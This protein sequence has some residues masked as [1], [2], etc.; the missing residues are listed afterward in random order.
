[1]T[2]TLFTVSLLELFLGGGG[3]LLEI[4]PFTARMLLFAACLCAGTVVMLSHRK[5]GDGV[6]LAIGL[7]AT[8]LCIHITGL[9][10]GATKGNDLTGAGLELQQSLY[11]LVAPFMATVLHSREMILRV[12]TLVR[13]AGAVL[14]IAYIGVVAALALGFIDYLSLYAILNATGEFAF[15]SES[16]FFYKG[17]LYLCISVIFFVAL[18]TRWKFAWTA[19]VVL[20]L[21]MTLTRGFVLAT[22]FA[23]MLLLVAQRRWR[24]LG[25]ALTIIA[26]VA[27]FLWGYLPS[28]DES[29]A[30]NRDD[31]NSQRIED[32]AYIVDNLK[33]SSLLFGEGLG[34]LINERLHIENTFL[35]AFWRL[36]IVGL[37]FWLTPLFFTMY[38][39]SRVR[40][41]SPDFDLA[42]AFGFS[43]VLVYVQTMSNPYLNN[44]IGLSFVIVSLFSLRTLSLATRSRSRHQ[45]AST[46]RIEP[47]AHRI[48]QTILH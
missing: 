11:W 19:L 47:P 35:W 12:A 34:A 30:T 14:A 37:A 20:A 44:P 48:A 9:L 6:F 29:L 3:R 25:L 21:A 39:F 13:F 42:C 5:R 2:E 10:V 7:V 46:K 40:R 36:G 15:R 18:P 45:T 31:S 43:T 24:T 16:F 32:F 23:A 8:Y 4:G 26:C 28:Q 27:F 38:Y 17:F 33:V 41:D 22:S 1:M